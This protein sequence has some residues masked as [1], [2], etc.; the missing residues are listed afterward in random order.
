MARMRPRHPE[1]VHDATARFGP[2]PGAGVPK[3][4][5]LSYAARAFA[6]MALA[7][8]GPDVALLW[9]PEPDTSYHQF[10]IGSAEAEAVTRAADAAFGQVLDAIALSATPTTVIAMSDH[11]QITTTFQTDITAEMQA[12]GLPCQPPSRRDPPPRAHK[13]QYG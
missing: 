11:G 13:G 6:D 1:A 5:T 4:D 12:V 10:G 8:Q 7:P 3:F 9:L 2:L